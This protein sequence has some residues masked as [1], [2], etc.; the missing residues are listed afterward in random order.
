MYLSFDMCGLQAPL[1]FNK[2][3]SDLVGMNLGRP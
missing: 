3:N 2:R 1:D